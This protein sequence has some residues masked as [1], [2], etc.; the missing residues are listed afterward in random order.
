MLIWASVSFSSLN[1]SLI[2][3]YH[4]SLWLVKREFPS[5]N[6]D[7]RY[8]YGDSDCELYLENL[9]V[10]FTWRFWLWKVKWKIW[11]SNLHGDF[12]CGYLLGKTDCGN[13][14]EILTVENQLEKLTVKFTWR[15]PLVQKSPKN[16]KFSQFSEFPCSR[17]SKCRHAA[18]KIFFAILFCS[19]F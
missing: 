7:L 16:P 3:L 5:L 9:T 17:V 1:T 13:Y 4:F 18:T 19:F 2:I 12:D 8:L 14:M 11:L 10:N 15:F 6:F